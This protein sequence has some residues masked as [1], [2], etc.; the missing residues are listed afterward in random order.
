MNRRFERTELLLGR[1]AMDIL[2]DCKVC[3]F[4]VGGVGSYTAE[5]LVRSGLGHI[6]L[7][8]YDRIEETNINRQV[9]A[10]TSTIGKFKVDV[11]KERL[12][13]INP[14]LKID[15][16]REKYT[17]ENSSLLI[18]KSYD[19]VVDAIDMVS[20][21]IDLIVK[22]KKMGIAIISSMGAGN[23]LDPTLFKVSDIY[24]TRNCPLARIMRKELRRR[25]VEDLKVVWSEEEALKLP[26]DSPNKGPAS[27]AYVP[28]VAGLIMAGQL[29]K[30]LIE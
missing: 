29:I 30:D 12:L 20:S 28:P 19:Y 11:M 26:E 5:A 24:E 2:K 23:K 4:G 17:S 13:D 14:N 22:S 6:V 9:H 1:E 25:G 10:L 8:D 7:V 27:L 3:V 21:K 16:F 15:I 18:N